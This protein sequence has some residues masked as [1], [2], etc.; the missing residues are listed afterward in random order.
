M[1]DEFSK[2]FVGWSFVAA[3]VM[4]WAGWVLLPVKI[5]TYFEPADF[6]RIHAQFQLWIWLFRVHIFGMVL[7][8]VALVALGSH[9]AHSSARVVLWPGIAVAAAGT[10]VGAL[11]SA[12]YYHHGAW[13][14]LETAGRSA[15]GLRAFVD[16]LLIDTE[17]V[18]CLVRFGRVFSGLGLLIVGFALVKWRIMASGI[19][20]AAAVL[21]LA[22][23]ALTMLLPDKMHLYWPLFH[24][25]AA[26]LA[27]TGIA[28][29]R[30]GL[31][32]TT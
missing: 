12:F 15:A 5:G 25:Q 1:D 9:L 18:T 27:V 29:L 30:G 13:G 6:A 7:T 2:R 16:S 32:G 22:A 10:I 28:V 17:Y 4:L 23:M 8:V 14:A 3:A 11:G 24:L 19:G 20:L 31:K 26:W 21:G